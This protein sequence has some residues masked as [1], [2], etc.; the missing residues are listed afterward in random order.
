VYGL[1]GALALLPI[2]QITVTLV[3]TAL[4]GY[5][6]GTAF[7]AAA[8]PPAAIVAI[9]ALAVAI[10]LLD[11]QAYVQ[12]LKIQ[13]YL[14]THKD[15]IICGLYTSGSA[16]EALAGLAAEVED[17]IQSVEWAVIFGGVIGPELAQLVGG[18]AAEAQT[19]NLVNP[20]FQ[21]T[22]DFAYPDVSCCLDGVPSLDWHFDADVEGWTFESLEQEGDDV[23]GSWDSGAGQPDPSD[24]SEGQ[25]R[26][27][28]T[29]AQ[30]PGGECHG[31]WAYDFAFGQMPE[32]APGDSFRVD[33]W[34]SNPDNVSLLLRIIYA[35]ATYSELFIPNPAVAWVEREVAATQ[36]K[37]VARLECG[38][39]L[40]DAAIPHTYR[41]DNARWG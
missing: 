4:G 24:S 15:T 16:G 40:G 32:V 10:G 7:G 14:R 38:F 41:M 12:F 26:C 25:L 22:E 30:P 18:M 1:F 9:A 37:F 28:I 13:D 39:G 2:L 3:G 27:T 33:I 29:R 34:S 21:V 31:I 17:A 23:E 11:A 8:F 6:A 20:L 5:I 35:D 19:N 36:G